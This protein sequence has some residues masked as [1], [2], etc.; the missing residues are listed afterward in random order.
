M[1]YTWTEPDVAV[2]HKGVEVYHLY[3]NDQEQSGAREY[4][5]CIDE[6]GSDDDN[7]GE[8]GVFDI[9][10]LPLK[11]DITK[12]TSLD[13]IKLAID[14]GFLVPGMSRDDLDNKIEELENEQERIQ[15]SQS[16]GIR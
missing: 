6:C 15:S 4:W 3:K 11:G 13:A 14:E 1:P 12:L 9:R 16:K 10:E 8:N 5:F 2:E 7:H